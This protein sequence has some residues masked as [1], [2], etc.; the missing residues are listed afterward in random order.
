[1]S[2]EN[3][4]FVEDTQAEIL[5]VLMAN[6]K[7]VFGEDMSDDEVANIRQFYR[8]VAML[9][10]DLQLDIGEVLSSAQL[11]YATGRALDLLVALI[12][13]NR[14][15]AIKAFGETT[16]SRDSTA[17][18]DYTVPKGTV[19]QTDSNDP[20]RFETKESYTL[21]AGTSAVSGVPIEALEAGTNSNIGSN[22][23]RVMTNPPAGIEDTTNPAAT[24]GGE[25]EESDEDLRSRA[26]SE[27][28]DGMRGTARAVRNQ[29]RKT[30]GVRSVSLFIN[31][32]EDVDAEG[33]PPQHTEYVVEGGVDQDV[34]QTIF[35]TKS[36]GD[37]TVGGVSGTGVEVQ[38]E[39][40]N[41]QTHP[42]NFTRST[43][44][45]IYI[46]LE[47]ETTDEFLGVDQIRDSIIRYLGGIITSGDEDDGELRVGDD[48]VYSKILSAIMNVNGVADASSLLIGKTDSPTGSSNVTITETEVATGD[49]TDG[50]ISITVV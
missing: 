49:A 48:A 34:G 12:G 7:A 36:S 27:L 15:S 14:K 17:D 41:G 21:T 26:R 18:V 47:I 22:S 43:L 45:Q 40:G 35:D 10:A 29:L 32:G 3:G 4:R 19:V 37:G 16:F 20:I 25:N 23:L 24:D 5:A 9:L 46:D 1:M 38:A 31:D 28:S 11:K 42:V 13:V 8:P 30:E 6:A 44:V 2:M 33:R 50:S 39:I